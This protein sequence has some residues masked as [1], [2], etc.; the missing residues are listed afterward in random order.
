MQQY[1]ALTKPSKRQWMSTNNT[2]PELSKDCW[3]MELVV[4]TNKYEPL[5]KATEMETD[6]EMLRKHNNA[7]P[8]FDHGVENIRAQQTVPD[9]TSKKLNV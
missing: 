7:P 1:D 6:H 3:L 2:R 9:E 4:T 5:E 8:I